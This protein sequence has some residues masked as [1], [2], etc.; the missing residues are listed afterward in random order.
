MNDR[1]NRLDHFRYPRVLSVDPQ[2]AVSARLS[3]MRFRLW[4]GGPRSITLAADATQGPLDAYDMLASWCNQAHV[5]AECIDVRSV[6]IVIRLACLPPSEIAVTV[7]ADGTHSARRL[8]G[9]ER[10]ICLALLAQWG[11]LDD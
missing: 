7:N 6:T 9:F 11:M 8:R 2:F 5:F 4:G 1:G 3:V 10:R